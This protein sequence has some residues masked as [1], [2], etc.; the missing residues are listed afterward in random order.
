MVGDVC[1]VWVRRRGVAFGERGHQRADI[2]NVFLRLVQQNAGQ[3]VGADE[4][5]PLHDGAHR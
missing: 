5:L 1:Y 2:V 3:A 4:A